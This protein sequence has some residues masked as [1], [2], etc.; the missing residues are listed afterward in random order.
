MRVK[1]GLV[2]GV[3]FILMLMFDVGRLLPSLARKFSL[4]V[5]RQTPD[6]RSDGC[7]AGPSLPSSLRASGV[8]RLPWLFHRH[9]APART[10]HGRGETPGVRGVAGEPENRRAAARHA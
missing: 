3:S 5:S 2:P 8:W 9:T 4:Q 6:V 10:R 7:G 1:M